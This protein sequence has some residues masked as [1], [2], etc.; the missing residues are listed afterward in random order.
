M[1]GKRRAAPSAPACN[2]ASVTIRRLEE[3]LNV[4][5]P[6]WG[7]VRDLA[8]R[9]PSAT[10]VNGDS[11]HGER[12]LWKL[13]V[14]ARS[15]LG[16]LALH[17]GGVLADHGWFRLFGG[18]SAHLI[19]LATANDLG[20]PREGANPP[21]YLLVGYD[22]LG[23]RFAIDGGGLGVAAGEVCYFG[24]DSLSWGGLGGGHADFVA[25]AIEGHLAD[26]FE[27]LRWTGWQ[28][29]ISHLRPDQ[30]LS[31]YPPPF[32]QEGKDLGAASRRPVPI[33]ELFNFYDDAARQL[34]P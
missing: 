31:I 32:T 15:Y 25:A 6:A 28:Q 13:Q 14:T 27:P 22:A 24:P 30:G 17:S 29:E 7:D 34:G 23:G 4:R 20:E 12:V 16:A 8:G 5:D 19:D 1:S 3:L 33:Q 26:A 21:P 18:G 11:E 10:I 9:N 2:D